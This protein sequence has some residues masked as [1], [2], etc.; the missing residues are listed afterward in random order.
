MKEKLKE[1]ASIYG[2]DSY[3]RKKNW[4]DSMN[5]SPLAFSSGKANEQH[6]EVPPQF[7]EEVLGP[8]MKYS[9]CFWE[10]STIHLYDAENQM[11]HL[12]TQ[13][14]GIK[15]GMKVLDLGCGWGSF[16]LYLAEKF[17]LCNICLLYTSPSPRD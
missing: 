6:Y 11:L 13:R 16:S 9:S 7:F 3:T 2:P 14:S 15:D 10:T 4:V 12:T 17:P 5:K 8:R 1:Q